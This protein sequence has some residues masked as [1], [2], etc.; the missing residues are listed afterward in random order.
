MQQVVTRAQSKML[1][2]VHIETRLGRSMWANVMNMIT[3]L[4]TYPGDKHEELN[5]LERST[6]GLYQLLSGV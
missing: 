1:E 6:K 5:I 2:W 3:F 4:G